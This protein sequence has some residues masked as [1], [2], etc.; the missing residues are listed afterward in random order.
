MMVGARAASGDP[1]WG[2]QRGCEATMARQLVLDGGG[3]GLSRA[4]GSQ[5][6]SSKDANIATG[7]VYKARMADVVDISLPL[8]Q[9]G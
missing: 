5:K 8:R 9:H 2:I 1:P 3:W 6:S 4:P 7:T